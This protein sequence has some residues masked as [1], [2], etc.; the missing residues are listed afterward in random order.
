MGFRRRTLPIGQ[1]DV[2]HVAVPL[3]QRQRHLPPAGPNVGRGIPVRYPINCRYCPVRQPPA[4]TRQLPFESPLPSCK[5]FPGI[6]ARSGLPDVIDI[7]IPDCGDVTLGSGGI[8][9]DRRFAAIAHP[10]FRHALGRRASDFRGNPRSTENPRMGAVVDHRRQRRFG[11]LL[12]HREH[13]HER[14]DRRARNHADAVSRLPSRISPAPVR[15]QHAPRTG[16]ALDRGLSEPHRGRSPRIIGLFD[17]RDRLRD[18]P[19]LPFHVSLA[20]PTGRGR[21]RRD[22][23]HG[24]GRRAI[25][26]YGEAGHILRAVRRGHGAERRPRMRVRRTDH[27]CL[28]TQPRHLRGAVADLPGRD[29]VHPR[30]IDGNQGPRPFTVGQHQRPGVEIVVH[31]TRLDIA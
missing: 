29:R 8:E 6:L 11:P 30:Q 21:D 7:D 19:R 4:Q 28:G 26:P 20:H 17:R 14:I 10:R 31:V 22:L 25:S 27:D 23:T 24:G 5:A 13:P 3:L 15:H 16:H 18:K 1:E 9:Y 2:F 12:P